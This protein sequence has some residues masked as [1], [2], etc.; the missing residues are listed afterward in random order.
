[1]TLGLLCAVVAVDGSMGMSLMGDGS[2]E[3]TKAVEPMAHMVDIPG[4][5]VSAMMGVGAASDGL[6]A[7]MCDGMCASDTG[8]TC[9]LVAALT[10]TTVLA[11]LLG[12][13]RDTFLGL[14]RRIPMG[15]PWRG[16]WRRRWRQSEVSLSDL[17]VLR[18]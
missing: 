17:C 8:D 9:T 7:S 2:A 6:L 4:A 10:V 11:L 18:I 3:V 16:R 13:R 12:R 14:M 5:T 15:P 1:M